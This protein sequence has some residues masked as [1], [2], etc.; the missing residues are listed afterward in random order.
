MDPNQTEQI[1]KDPVA[2][3][4]Q[5]EFYFSDAN[6]PMDKFFLSLTKGSQNKPV[7]IK[8]IHG[9]KR[10]RHFQPYTTVVAALEDSEKLE[11]IRGAG[12]GTE[13][14]K[15]KVPLSDEF[16]V[17]DI[18]KNKQIREATANSRTAYVYG[19]KEE[20]AN[21]QEEVE[22]W[23]KALAPDVLSVRLERDFQGKFRN[24]VFIELGDKSQLEEFLEQFE[25]GKEYPEDQYVLHSSPIYCELLG[26]RAHDLAS[27]PCLSWTK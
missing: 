1:S 20:R 6:L 11:V 5:V 13:V 2:I 16:T 3:R 17:D 22:T 18:Y 8:L 27:A 26:S 9:F 15:R 12:H 25:G 23:A 10:M 24:G 19:F 21:H 14:V 4:Q 7:E